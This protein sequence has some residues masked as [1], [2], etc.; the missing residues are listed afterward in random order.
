MKPIHLLLGDAT[1]L[2]VRA[3]DALIQ[4]ALSG[5]PASFNLSTHSGDEASPEVLDLARTPPMM[6]GNRVVV[7]RRIDEA[8]AELIAALA[9]YAEHPNPTTVLVLTGATLPN[10]KGA[11]RLNALVK[12]V[13]VVRRFDASGQP[14]IDFALQAARERGCE[15]DRRAASLLVE[16]AGRD[17]GRIELEVDKLATWV[18]GKGTI[19]VDAVEEVSSMV[20]EAVVWEVTDAIVA[21]DADR[22]LAT[23]VR[24]LETERGASHR[25]LALVTW[26]VRQ[27]L[28]LQDCIRRGEAPPP[29]WR[30][31]PAGRKAELARRQL[32]RHPLP[33]ARILG[34]LARTNRQ[35][36]R[37][38]IGDRRV[39]EALV[40]ELTTR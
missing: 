3:T 11:R 23:V 12:K 32:E 29:A 9:H 40:M 20:A 1:P 22:A 5:G 6:G 25:M 21:R 28:E 30:R 24:L 37:A 10:V 19:G 33:S 7:I 34:A 26:Q 18:G 8:K 36:N 39:F 2:L 27:L 15:L 13:G 4:E 16:L 14:P 17:L 38:A 35:L 31:G